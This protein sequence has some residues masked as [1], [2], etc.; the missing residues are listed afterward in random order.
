M[1]PTRTLL[2]LN[3]QLQIAGEIFYTHQL[4][5]DPDC[6]ALYLLHPQLGELVLTPKDALRV[7]FLDLEIPTVMRMLHAH[8]GWETMS[9]CE[10][11]DLIYSTQEN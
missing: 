6:R 4:G 10:L 9:L 2:P 7:R 3:G 1:R 5:L 11:L 8:G